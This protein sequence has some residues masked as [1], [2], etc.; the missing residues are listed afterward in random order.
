VSAVSGVDGGAFT[1][2][3]EA[4]AAVEAGLGFLASA[5]VAQWPPDT[6]AGCLR[7]LGRVES[8]S[9]RPGHAC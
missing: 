1:T 5:E 7:A 4:L 2:A 8:A 9:W 3:A 6:L